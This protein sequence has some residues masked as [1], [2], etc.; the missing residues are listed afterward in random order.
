MVQH[1]TTMVILPNTGYAQLATN[2]EY[3]VLVPDQTKL[4]LILKDYFVAK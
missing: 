2:D 3:W 4:V 1:I